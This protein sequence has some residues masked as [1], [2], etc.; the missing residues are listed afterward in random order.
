M[1]VGLMIGIGTRDAGS[2]VDH[3]VDELLTVRDA[4][5]GEDGVH[6]ACLETRT[7]Q[8]RRTHQSTSE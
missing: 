2:P 8:A 5:F 7:L 1:H 4:G 3:Y 6:C